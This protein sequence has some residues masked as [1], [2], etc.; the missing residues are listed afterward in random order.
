MGSR[1]RGVNFHIGIREGMPAILGHIILHKEGN[2]P[3]H[4]GNP[5]SFATPI[6]GCRIFRKDMQA[7]LNHSTKALSKALAKY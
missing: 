1:T 3:V 7:A 2:N 5:D 4:A 6:W